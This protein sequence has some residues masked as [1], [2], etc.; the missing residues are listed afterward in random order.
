VKRRKKRY[1]SDLSN[2][3]WK[4]LKRLMPVHHGPGR[5]VSLSLGHILNAIFYVI[6]TGCQ[7]RELPGDF[8]VWSSVYY[9]YRKWAKDGTW[10]QLNAALCQLERQKRGRKAKPTGAKFG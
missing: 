10:R 1:T 9:H 2:K 8:P 5:E 4:A 6:R 3:E 7:W